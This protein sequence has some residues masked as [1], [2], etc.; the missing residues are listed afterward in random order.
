MEN[1]FIKTKIAENLYLLRV[2]DNDTKYFEALWEIPEGI[3]YNAYLIKTK[4]GNVLIDGWK[5]PYSEKLLELLKE[6]LKDLK[7]IIVNHTE[8]DHSGS[9]KDILEY[10]KNKP[11]VLGTKMAGDLLKSFYKIDINFKQVEDGEEIKVGEYTLKFFTTPWLHWPD[12]MVTYVKELKFM[13]TCDIFGSYGIFDSVYADE[14]NFDNYE[15]FIRKYTSTV[16][17]AYKNYIVKNIDK[18]KNLGLEI[19]MIL[20]GHGLLWRDPEK[21]I[22]YFYKIG[23]ESIR[24]KKVTI[25]YNSMYGLIDP[26]ILFTKEFIEKNGYETRV[27]KC[28]DKERPYISDIISETTD[29]SL[30]IYGISTYENDVFPIAKY[31]LSML[32][33]KVNN[34]IPII[35]ITSYGWGPVVKQ[36]VANI[37]KGTKFIIV[38]SIEFRGTNSK[39]DEKKIEEALAKLL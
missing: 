20:P 19:K 10:T 3:M 31:I 16:I 13:F 24:S 15:P 1:K 27:F 23:N 29:S 26:A 35:I 36:K 17:G 22:D 28:T 39:D 37:I 38:D 6:D 12:T 2:S 33:N 4:E 30:I 14:I 34:K 7:I 32:S 18:I 21:I 9:I 8:P 25:I 11:L 5:K